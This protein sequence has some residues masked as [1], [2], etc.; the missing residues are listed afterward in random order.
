MTTQGTAVVGALTIRKT[1]LQAAW[2][3]D[4]TKRKVAR[5]AAWK[6]YRDAV[7]AARKKFR[8]ETAAIEAKFKVAAKACGADSTE[9]PATEGLF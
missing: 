9:T 8:T 5:E 6:K 2:S 3:G 4:A 1:D 7:A